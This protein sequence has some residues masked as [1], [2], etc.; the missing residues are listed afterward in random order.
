MGGKFRNLVL[1]LKATSKLKGGEVS[2]SPGLHLLVIY[3]EDLF[4]AHGR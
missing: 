2:Y 4:E 1:R 3:T